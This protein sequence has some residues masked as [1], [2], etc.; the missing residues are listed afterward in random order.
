MHK[1]AWMQIGGWCLAAVLMTGLAGCRKPIS[2]VAD[3]VVTLGPN[4]KMRFIYIPALKEYVAKYEV[5][6][7][8]YRCYKPAHTSGAYQQLTLDLDDQPAV[9]VSW[10]EARQ[11][12]EWLTKTCGGSG[13]QRYRFRLPKEQEWET[14]AAC[15]LQTEYPWGADWPPPKNWNY[16]G[17]ENPELSPKLDTSDKFQVSCPAQKSGANAWGLCGVGGNVWEW[18]EDTDGESQ[19]RVYKGASWSD[20]H[21]LFLKL[22]RR[23]SNAPD[24]KYVNLGFRVVADVS[25][26]SAGEKKKPE[27]EQ[28]KKADAVKSAKAKEEAATSRRVVESQAQAEQEKKTVDQTLIQ[29]LIADKKFD[30][31]SAQIAQYEKDYGKDAFSE[32]CAATLDAAEH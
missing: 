15:G 22:T 31:A 30:L 27:D 11:F 8:E 2:D 32:K 3:L 25:S 20:C 23:S 4:T 21:Q 10:N 16:Y 7:K 26:V 12:C 18:C 1:H 17:R 9:N 24:Y 29:G 19:A 28:H 14:F 5:S 13:T 6:N